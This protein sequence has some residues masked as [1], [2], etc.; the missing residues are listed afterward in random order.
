MTRFNPSLAAFAL[1]CGAGALPALA[2]SSASS[3]ASNSASTSVGS[4]STS[5]EKSSDSS[6][7]NNVAEGDY[8]IIEMAA[9]ADRP[10]AVRL[11]LQ[12]LAERG[13]AGEF[14]LVLPQQ[15]V[16][17]GRL[18]AGQTV[19]ARQRAYGLEFARSETQQAFFLVLADDWYRE[20]QTN[21]VRL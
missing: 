19:T 10:G 11:K 13:A 17:Q 12:A 20:L 5:V 4:S 7:G 15:A 1:L 14:F 3:A 9:A 6:K 21:P 8:R 18:A 16:D 2:E